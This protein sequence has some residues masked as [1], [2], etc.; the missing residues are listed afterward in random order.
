MVHPG[1]FSDLPVEVFERTMSVN[2]FGTLY[3]VRAVLPSMREQRS[4]HIVLI[5]SGAALLGIYGYT[6]YSASKFAMRGLAE[7]LRAELRP[8]HIAVSIA[9]P[10]DTDT[11]QL[12]EENRL[13]PHATRQITSG[14]GLMQAEAV[15]QAIVRGIERRAFIIAPGLE[16][17]LLARLHSLLAPLLNWH[18]DRIVRRCG[19]K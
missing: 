10:P 15:A 1:H 18:F 3:A 16:M 13:K 9:Y 2:Y 12:A 6:A 5:S 17:T 4:G 19:V 8:L 7:S 11:P 14:G